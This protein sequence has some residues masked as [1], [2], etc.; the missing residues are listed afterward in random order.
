M[1]QRAEF[2]AVCCRLTRKIGDTGFVPLLPDAYSLEYLMTPGALAVYR[3]GHRRHL[4]K[5]APMRADLPT[6]DGSALCQLGPVLRQTP[7][8][9]HP[10]AA[11]APG[12]CR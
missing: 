11:L 3:V 5:N 9:A 2:Q 4:H 6:V 1:K 7:V 12:H 10:R 8:A